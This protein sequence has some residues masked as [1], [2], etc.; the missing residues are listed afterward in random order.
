MRLTRVFVDAALTAGELLPL[1]PGPAQHL[2]KVL[3]LQAGATIRVFNG[4]GGEFDATIE[5]AGKQQV[6]ARIGTHHAIDRESPLRVTLLQGVARGER[7]DFV[8]QKATELG[9]AA[10]VPVLASRSTVR[11]DQDGAERKRAHW[12]GVLAGACEQCG[13]NV[14]PTLH[15]A[16]RLPVALAKCDSALKL[17]LEPTTDAATLQQLLKALPEGR[18]ASV[19]LLVGPEGGLDAD[20]L[21]T[22][23][24]AGFVSCRLGPRVLRTETAALAALAALQ[25]LA[26]DLS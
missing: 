9:V 11:L 13:R 2:V 3:R 6:L 15:A 1:P 18:N 19:C 8:L 16:A 5:S 14:L 20:E 10:V 25:A 4:R 24:E 21:R 23:K 7:M 12:H 17:V 22:A 26:G